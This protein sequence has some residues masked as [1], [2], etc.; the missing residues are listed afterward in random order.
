MTL[1]K[2]GNINP[3]IIE[4]QIIPLQQE[5]EEIEAN[6]IDSTSLNAMLESK[7]DEYSSESIRFD[8]ERFEEMLNDDN[9]IEMRSLVREY[10]KKITLEPKDNPKAK[11]KWKRHVHIDS[12]VR[13]LTMIKLASP[14]GFEPLSP[15]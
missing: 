5:K 1:Y 6:I 4:S 14:R 8:L 13:A 9:L 3:E 7:V 15:A 2:R 10:I 12:Y 11:K